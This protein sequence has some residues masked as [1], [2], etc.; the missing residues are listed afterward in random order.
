MARP[1]QIEGV[2]CGTIRSWQDLIPIRT[3]EDLIDLPH[4]GGVI[5]GTSWV[6]L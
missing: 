1:K 4:G 3:L 2:P 6:T 5:S